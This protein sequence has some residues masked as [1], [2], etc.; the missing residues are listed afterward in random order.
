MNYDITQQSN[1]IQF[2]RALKKLLIE[3]E[4]VL[5]GYAKAHL[6]YEVMPISSYLTDLL[7]QTTSHCCEC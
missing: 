2:S 5:A 4:E 7:L 1:Q 6:H 3:T